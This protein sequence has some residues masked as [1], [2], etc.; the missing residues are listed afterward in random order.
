M[1]LILDVQLM[2]SK[3]AIL[4]FTLLMTVSVIIVPIT[5]IGESAIMMDQDEGVEDGEHVHEEKKGMRRRRR[6]LRRFTL[7]TNGSPLLRS[8]SALL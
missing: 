7:Q 6:G 4:F 1:I 8:R 5:S 2:V 3:L